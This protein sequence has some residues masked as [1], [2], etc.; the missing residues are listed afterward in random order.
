MAGFGVQPA[1]HLL[2]PGFTLA[3][4]RTVQLCHGWAWTPNSVRYPPTVSLCLS[5]KGLESGPFQTPARVD[6][7]VEMV[8]GQIDDVAAKAKAALQGAIEQEPTD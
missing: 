1:R 8:K 7:W 6:S 2:T 3:P 5:L 4:G